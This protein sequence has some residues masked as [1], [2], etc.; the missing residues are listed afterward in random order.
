MEK[1]N[2]IIHTVSDKCH[3]IIKRIRKEGK[4]ARKKRENRSLIHSFMRYAK[5]EG[6]RFIFS[7]IIPVYNTEEY[8]AEAIESVIDQKNL[9]FRHTEII[10]VNDGST[11]GS[12][13]ICLRYQ[14]QYPENIKYIKQENKGVSAA[15]N[16]GI[17]A[18]EGLYLNFLDSDDK[19]SDTSFFATIQF[20]KKFNYPDIAAAKE[21]FFGAKTGAHP[22][23]FVFKEE[24]M[25]DLD[26]EFW[27][28]PIAVPQAFYKYSVI[29]TTRFQEGL[30]HSEDARF[31]FDS[32]IKPKTFGAMAQPT[33]LYRKRA[34]HSSATDAIT[35]DSH[36]Y[37]DGITMYHD[38]LIS[39]SEEIFGC[40]PKFVQNELA[41]N[42][43]W[44]LRDN[45]GDK[46]ID[47]TIIEEYRVRLINILQK[48][49][50]DVIVSQRH[51]NPY[52]KLYALSLKHGCSLQKMINSL[53]S[54]QNGRV[55]STIPTGEI[56]VFDL[57]DMNSCKIEFYHFTDK[58]TIILEG[59]LTNIRGETDQL[60]VILK[61]NGKEF[62]SSLYERKHGKMQIPFHDAD[63]DLYQIHFR[64][65]F[66][67]EEK[68]QIGAEFSMSDDA[69]FPMKLKFGPF[70]L[71]SEKLDNNYCIKEGRLYYCRNNTLFI[72]NTDESMRAPL[73][74]KLCEELEKTEAGKKWIPYRQYAI[75]HMQDSENLWLFTDRATSAED[76]GEEF[77]RFLINHPVEDVE[78]AFIIRKDEP[79]YRRL[80]EVGRVIPFE[81]EEHFYAMLRA[82]YV[83]SSSGDN[84]VMN[85]FG[86][87]LK[88]VK[89]L[90]H[91]KFVFL[92]HGVIKD[93]LS[94][95]LHRSNKNIHLFVVSAER[96]RQS[97]LS[98]AY[99]YY[100]NQVILTGLPR[101][102]KL[103]RKDH[104]A[105]QNAVYIMPTWRQWLAPAF[106]VKAENV[107]EIQTKQTGFRESD[108]FQ[109]YNGLLSSER[110]HG[111]L[112]THDL[113]VYF[114]LHPRMG[115][116]MDSFYSDDRV[117]LLK[118]E[119]FVYGDAFKEMKLLITDYSSVAF[120]VALLRKPVI[121]A[122]FDFDEFYNSG[123]H[124]SS[125][126]YFSF[127]DDGFGPVVT[128][129]D[130][131]I[132][133]IE[134]AIKNSF[135]M[136]ELYQKRAD[137]FF[138][139]PENGV[140][141]SEMVLRYIL[142]DRQSKKSDD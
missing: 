87:D 111:L 137:D 85:P 30:K 4:K 69:L 106:D 113:H 72:E 57:E 17:E 10:L 53:K 35:H 139:Q 74:E 37:T 29:G 61:C 46:N 108:Y 102:D 91:A 93:D 16:R 107:D 81:S 89:D 104:E 77:W 42:I 99:G 11:D 27:S 14:S 97:I 21:K 90:L 96:E 101:F 9:G 38:Y 120:N 70:A 56:F 114:A 39:K 82:E 132:S 94:G 118:P 44:R 134:K 126:G 95:W 100:G 73:E 59:T 66:P 84:W 103:L 129:V 55:F 3:R 76:S 7:V 86:K 121:Y 92:Q 12:E 8:L 78:T 80:T 63:C 138:Y 48:I 45:P 68:L 1:E 33:Y 6:R 98:A 71:I 62:N 58:H 24:R 115:A 51:L 47:E 36:Y 75:E 125:L 123:K 124:T 19:W 119:S 18:A 65:E 142:Q 135:R 20:L 32:L 127:Q 50:D 54:D 13:E 31:S 128:T 43:G 49:D 105:T 141:H 131:V 41:Y 116:E 15:R 112:R 117:H 140:T 83:I 109:F 52:Q 28:T 22:R 133:E 88:Y 64:V 136:N 5:K 2:Q 122:Q 130:D 60:R 79:D 67:L 26:K 110:L 34:D 25:V 23:N 40:L